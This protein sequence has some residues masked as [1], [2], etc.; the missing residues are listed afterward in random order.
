[1][2]KIQ[3]NIAKRYAKAIFEAVGLANT[4][5]LQLLEETGLALG[6][7]S[8][9]WTS[10]FSLRQVLQNPSLAISKRLTVAQEVAKLITTNSEVQKDISNLLCLLLENSRIA[11]ISEVARQYLVMLAEY[12]KSLSLEVSTAKE[13]SADEKAA[14][15]SQV[16][17]TLG[18]AATVSW[19]V[20]AA[21]IGGMTV[22]SGDKL[23]DGSVKTALEK[24]REC[25]V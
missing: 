2:A 19:A 6:L 24:M 7:V 16:K 10:D 21:L 14:L 17:S 25:L 20:D 22:K 15:L 8:D 4:N 23:L 12:K 9:V 5:S 11:L 1:M 18:S 3:G 13:L